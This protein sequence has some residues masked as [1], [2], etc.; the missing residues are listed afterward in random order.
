[1]TSEEFL[2][3]VQANVLRVREY[4]SGGDGSGGRCDC[5]GLIIG[6]WRLSGNKWPWTHGSNYAARYLTE[7][8]GMG[9]EL[10]P[11]DLV[12]KARPP[13]EKGYD[14]PDRYSDDPDMNDYYHVGIVTAVDPLTIT[15]CTSVEG[16]IR[17]DHNRGAWKY[18]GQLR[19]LEDGKMAKEMIVYAENGK[20]VNLRQKASTGSYQVALVPLGTKVTVQ[21]TTNTGWSAVQYN[22]KQ[23]YMMSRFLVE[24]LPAEEQTQE[25]AGVTAADAAAVMKALYAA[26]D[27]IDQALQRMMPAG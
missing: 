25:T 3:W 21:G 20:P 24:Q 10:R 4:Q 16:G 26:R 6:A 15:H 7:N 27:A 13:G 18:S 22:G 9:K 14:L 2:K 11:G 23:G 1:M 17:E 19:L 8:L 12:Y 5:I